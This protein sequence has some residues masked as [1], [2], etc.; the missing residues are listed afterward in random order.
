[1][2]LRITAAALVLSAN[3]LTAADVQGSV[4]IE[5]KLTKRQVTAAAGLYQRASTVE[6]GANANADPLAYERSHVAVYIE[7]AASTGTPSAS[8]PG[9]EI[10]QRD[11]RFV[12]DFLVIPA[13]AS[14]SFPNFD[15]IFHNV[16]SLSKP[17]S[18]DLGN[19]PKGQTRKVTFAKPGIVYVNCHLHPNM[20]ATIVVSPSAWVTT[21]SADGEFRLPEVPPGRYTVVA[22]HK[23]AGFFRQTVE[24]KAAT[25]TGLRFVIPIVDL[26]ATNHTQA[27][28]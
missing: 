4:I 6:L 19:Y 28:R 7:S 12:P 5:R 2:T 18:F 22:W 17:K 1:M 14:V 27:H 11:R 3:A 26:P 15:P 10:E 23:A 8:V 20:A 25:V 9:L 24:V 13:G 21:A 16:F